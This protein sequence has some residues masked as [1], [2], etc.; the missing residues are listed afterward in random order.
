MKVWF[1]LLLIPVFSFSQ[2]S[3]T[4]ISRYKSQAQNV[5][6]IRDT[7]GVPHIYGKTD[8]DAVFGLLYAQCEENFN[9]VEKN[10]LEMLGRLSEISGK[11]QLYNDLQTRLIY[12]S[13]AAIADYK[14]SPLWLKKL[15][16]AAADGVNYYLFKHPEVKPA[17]LKR[18]EPWYALMR[19][20][21]SISATQTGGLTLNHLKN[22]YPLDSNNISFNEKPTVLYEHEPTGSNGFAVAPSMT[23]SKNAIL[24]INPHT[25][26]YFRSEVQMVS[27]EGLNAYGAVTW[28]TFFVY[29]GFNEHCGW[30]HTSSYADVADLFAEKITKKGNRFYYQYD[31]KLLPVKTK[32]IS[33]AYKE[34]DIIK[35]QSFITYA[36]LHGPVM[37]RHENKWLSLK[38]NNRSLGALMQSWLRTRAKGFEDFR[39]IMNMRVNNSNNTVFA[40]DRGNIAYWHG[41]FMPRRNA[42]FDYSFQV[43]GSISAT[44]W[45][46]IHTVDETV[47]VYN[48]ASGWIQNCN[49][50]PF[51][52]SGKSSP[53]KENYPIY[54]APD[55]QN[56]RGINAERLLNNAKDITIDK[57][58]HEIGYSRYLSAFEILLPELFNAYNVTDSTHPLKTKLKEAIQ[59]LKGWD[60]NASASSV[61]SAI[62]IE[63]AYNLSS[64]AL[65]LPNPYDASNSVKQMK[66]MIANTTSYEKLESLSVTL[67]SLEIRFGVWKTAWGEVNRYQRPVS[68]SFNDA[69]PSLPVGLGPGTWGSLPSFAT[70][71]FPDTNKRYGISG[72]SF[73]A[74]VEFGKKLKAKSV[75]IGGQSFDPASKHFTNQA[76]MYID[77]NFKDVLFYKDDVLKHA[78]RKYHPGE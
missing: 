33:I 19:T 60:M 5:T 78:E 75:I 32:R 21:G 12:D 25:S 40:D 42:A 16:D 76:Q 73:I 7:W 13:A 48:P 77:G 6:I 38:E 27:E 66:S 17:V 68:G 47:H 44:N 20:D 37:G 56:F 14:R 15:M 49:A 29:Q 24:Y 43:D 3:Q 46:G 58:I 4:E 53:V 2:F 18:F 35:Q 22:F 23:A 41:N 54:M 28:G 9:Q 71:R 36:T 63:F 11:E 55:G 52:V 62:A 70:K 50:T 8:A 31:G 39:K 34:G 65:P 26:F 61:A 72:N 69:Q 30:M 74:C 1:C 45:K 67:D 59:I 51:T 10:N 64:K 57:M